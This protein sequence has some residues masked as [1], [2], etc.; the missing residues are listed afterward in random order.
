MALTAGELVF[1]EPIADASETVGGLLLTV[2]NMLT[3]PSLDAIPVLD[4]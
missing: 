3:V 4:L 1:V 2:S